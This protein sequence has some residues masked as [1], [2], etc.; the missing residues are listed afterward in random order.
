MKISQMTQLCFFF[1]GE[2]LLLK[3]YKYPFEN[4]SIEGLVQFELGLDHL[5]LVES[6]EASSSRIPSKV[7]FELNYKGCEPM[8]VISNQCNPLVGDNDEQRSFLFFS[9]SVVNID[10]I[11]PFPTVIPPLSDSDN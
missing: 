2:L 5:I 7:G 3:N 9:Y 4:R 10:D 1:T 8:R 6:F 11:L